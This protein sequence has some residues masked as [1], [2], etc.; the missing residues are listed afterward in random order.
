MVRRSGRRRVRRRTGGRVVSP[1]DQAARD[2][3]HADLGATLFVEAGAG[4]G[5]TS[6]LVGRIVQLVLHGVPIGAIA[7]ITFT[8]KAAADLRRRLRLAL[9]QA[10][11]GDLFQVQQLDE[12]LDQL[13]HAPIGTLHAFARRL[14]NE[15][16]IQAGLPPGFTVLD[17]LESNIA[18][19]ERWEDLLEQLL[20]DAAPA[21]GPVDGGVEFVQ[22]LEFE[23]FGIRSTFRRVAIDFH[24]NWDL[25]ASRVDRDAPVRW[26][27]DLTR[28]AALVRHAIDVGDIPPDDT[29]AGTLAELRQVEPALTTEPTMIGKLQHAEWLHKRLA[30]AGKSGSK[31]KWK[32]YGGDAALDDVRR[33]QLDVAEAAEQVLDQAR[34]HR[35]R[36]VGA[37][38][39]RWVLESAERR[40]TDGTVEFHDLL[41]LARR[42]LTDHPEIRSALHQRYQRLMLDEFQDTDPIQLEIAVRLSAAPDDP[43]QS[44]DWRALRPVPGRL[45]IVGDPKQ[46][47][48]RFRRADIAQYLRAADQIGADRVSLTA[49]FRSSEPVIRWVNSVFRNLIVEQVDA[50]PAFQRLDACRAHHI[51]HG[52]VRVIG[53]TAH[54]ELAEHRSNAEALRWREAAEAADAVATA[55]HEGWLVTDEHTQQLRRCVPGDITVLLPARTSLAALEA[56]LVER[57]LP[58]RAENSS[59]VYTTR[60]DPASDAGIARRRRP[61]RRAGARGR[62]AHRAVRVQRRRV[63]RV[64]AGRRIVVDLAQPAGGARRPP[65]R[66]ID[67]PR[68]VARRTRRLAR[69]GRSAGGARRRAAHARR[70]ARFA[71]RA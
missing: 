63:V 4:A 26:Q 58:Y 36:L 64:E 65:G 30:K 24:A 16:P 62:P 9:V 45:F 71:R 70:R 55:L 51:E 10:P 42:L 69:S 52:T 33:R 15:F 17:E 19:D 39:G 28:L 40:A 29:Q 25:V 60:R 34:D 49:N 54:A 41:V 35:R 6:S 13:D 61:H 11:R 53:V 23:Q 43:A 67:R 56:A 22:L 50:Q 68:P 48:Y 59:V 31:A 3:V 1:P 7:A 46:S 38:L 21:A 12:A 5:K 8:E 20:A 37:I 27:P 47:I 57:G 18:F 2:R 44:G 32:H 14:L 66:R